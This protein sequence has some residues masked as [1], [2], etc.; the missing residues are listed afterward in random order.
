MRNLHLL[1]FALLSPLTA[2]ADYPV[3]IKNCLDNL[4]VSVDFGVINNQAFVRLENYEIREIFCE[5]LFKASSDKR[6]R[7]TTI[8]PNKQGIMLYSPQRTVTRMYITVYC[9]DEK[10]SLQ[11]KS[12][13]DY[14]CVTGRRD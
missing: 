12:L 11:D 1:I 10:E 3:S 2:A 8:K 9:S 14:S 7:K 5:T 13:L 4:S 6:T